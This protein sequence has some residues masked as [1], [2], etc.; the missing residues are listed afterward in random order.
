MN[1][2]AAIRDVAHDAVPALAIML[3]YLSIALPVVQDLFGL[4]V[5]TSEDV[6]HSDL[7]WSIVA[8]RCAMRILHIIFYQLPGAILRPPS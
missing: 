4:R 3:K 1:T 7:R 5:M 6:A 8:H 2:C